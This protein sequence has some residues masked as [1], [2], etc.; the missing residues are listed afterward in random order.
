MIIQF[1]DVARCEYLPTGYGEAKIRFLSFAGAGPIKDVT[2]DVSMKDVGFEDLTTP[3]LIP[4]LFLNG[5]MRLTTVMEPLLAADDKLENEIRLIAGEGDEELVISINPLF[6][7][8]SRRWALDFIY[9]ADD[10]SS[11]AISW[12]PEMVGQEDW[13]S[14]V[15]VGLSWP[16]IMAVTENDSIRKME[17]Q[18]YIAKNSKRVSVKV[19]H[20]ILSDALKNTPKAFQEFAENYVQVMRKAKEIGVDR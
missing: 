16:S 13:S 14:V 17:L 5:M 4:T 8:S 12:T 1:G 3:Y 15:S 7:K 20:P 2:M 9:P 6:D 11:G 10:G 19:E 18:A